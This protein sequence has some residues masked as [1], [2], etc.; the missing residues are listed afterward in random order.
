VLIPTLSDNFVVSSE[1]L[2]LLYGSTP[3]LSRS[4]EIYNNEE[5]VIST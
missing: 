4:V 5:N 2:A 3:L 1:T